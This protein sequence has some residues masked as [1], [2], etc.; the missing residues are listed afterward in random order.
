MTVHGVARAALGVV[1]VLVLGACASTRESIEGSPIDSVAA[2]SGVWEGTLD[3][4]FGPRVATLT[5]APDGK[6][7]VVGQTA[8]FYG[9]V[10][11]T[12]GKGS[13]DFQTS[14]GTV[15]LYESSSRRQLLLH[16]NDGVF[17][18]DVSRK[19]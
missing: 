12:N 2:I 14:Q 18:L 7:T 13:Y 5:L 4:G 16:S 9:R 1:L 10:I 17:D 8:T 19:R 6:A 11:A 15:R 3:L